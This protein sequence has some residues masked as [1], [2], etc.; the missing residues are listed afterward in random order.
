[1]AKG[2]AL[3]P[4]LA[5][6]GATG[7]QAQ[8]EYF[9]KISAATSGFHEVAGY[10]RAGNMP[11]AIEHNHVGYASGGHLAEFVTGSEQLGRVES[12]QPDCLL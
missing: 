12:C 6:F 11:F 10:N 5:F 2:A 3:G 1:V 9:I 7:R 8:K 4:R